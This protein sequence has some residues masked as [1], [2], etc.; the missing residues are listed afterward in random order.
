MIW[1]VVSMQPQM[2]KVNVSQ[3]KIKKPLN[4]LLTLIK[5]F[6]DNDPTEK[7]LKGGNDEINV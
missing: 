7:L 5:S 2:R 4:S 3:R 1:E 6:I